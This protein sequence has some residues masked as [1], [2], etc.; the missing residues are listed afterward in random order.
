MWDIKVVCDGYYTDI[1]KA[2]FIVN[3]LEYPT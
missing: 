2:Y 3:N 1:F